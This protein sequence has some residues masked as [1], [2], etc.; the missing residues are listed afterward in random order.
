MIG[1]GSK[2]LAFFLQLSYYSELVS[3]SP[4]WLSYKPQ[5]EIIG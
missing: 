4:F 5:A 3:Q 2:E 1:Q